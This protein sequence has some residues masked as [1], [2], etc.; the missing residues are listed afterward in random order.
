M[1]DDASTDETP[2]HRHREAPHEHEGV[3]FHLRREH[4]GEGKA[5]TINHGLGVIQADGWY[6]AVL[7]IDADV[8][9]TA[10]ALRTDDP[11]A[12][13]SERGRRDGLHQGGK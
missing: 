7:V 12:R 8:L 6:E 10:E 13:R 4:G 3:V 2:A 1:V 11:A 9:L 5:A